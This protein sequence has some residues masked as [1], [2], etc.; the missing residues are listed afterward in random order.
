MTAWAQQLTACAR[1]QEAI[2]IDPPLSAGSA[3]IS[4]PFYPYNESPYHPYTRLL[5]S[6]TYANFLQIPHC[7]E[8]HGARLSARFIG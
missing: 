8:R 4:G 7:G 5:K 1:Q 6:G 3:S 2:K